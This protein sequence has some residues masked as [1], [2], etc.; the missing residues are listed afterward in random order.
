MP[1]LDGIQMSV[2][3][4][5][6]FR[7]FGYALAAAVLAS[8]A[9]GFAPAWLAA[10]TEPLRVFANAGGLGG[11]SPRGA[12]L[13][14]TL[15]ALQMGASTILLLTA[16]LFVR[17]TLAGLA[18]GPRVNMDHTALGELNL[19]YEGYDEAHGRMTPEYWS[20]CYTGEPDYPIRRLAQMHC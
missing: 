5:L 11:A 9:V 18:N 7:V 6:D 14:T 19:Q 17:S 3:T 1:E 4:S 20:A 13:R 2:D 12:R 10:R 8:C 16:G 15:L